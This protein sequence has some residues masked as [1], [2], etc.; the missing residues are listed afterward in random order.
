MDEFDK[1]SEKLDRDLAKVG[2]EL[3]SSG[4]YRLYLSASGIMVITGSSLMV[5]ATIYHERVVW[6]VFAMG[7]TQVI[8]GVI[9][10]AANVVRLLV[11]ALQ[12]AVG[13][14]H[15]A[16]RYEKMRYD[17][18]IHFGSMR[19]KDLPGAPWGTC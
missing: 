6:Q 11:S 3:P 19:A 16:L 8:V 1:D 13:F 18:E 10:L 5:L 7:A 4:R 14:A 2:K 12:N 17:R 9:F 15:L